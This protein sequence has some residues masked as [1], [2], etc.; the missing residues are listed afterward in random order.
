MEDPQQRWLQ[1][2]QANEEAWADTE[3]E[4]GEAKVV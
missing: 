1:E 2:D 4:G 3:D